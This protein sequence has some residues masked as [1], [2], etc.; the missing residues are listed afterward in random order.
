VPFSSKFRATKSRVS[1]R[2]GDALRLW[3]SQAGSGIAG[4]CSP[5]LRFAFRGLV[6][7]DIVCPTCIPGPGSGNEPSVSTLR[8][9]P[10][11]MADLRR[12]LRFRHR[13][14]AKTATRMRM[15]PT[16]DNQHL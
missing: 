10:G 6:M 5:G 7:T 1:A 15:K 8:F 3:L 11:E 9:P 12:G 14:N 2:L 16:E 4:T 13:M